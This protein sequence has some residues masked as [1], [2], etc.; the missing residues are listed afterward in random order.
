MTADLAQ[1]LAGLRAFRGKHIRSSNPNPAG[2]DE[3]EQWNLGWQ[4]A[5]RA[6]AIG[7]RANHKARA[8]R[9]GMT[10]DEYRTLEAATVGGC[11]ICQGEIPEVRTPVIDHDHRSNEIRG[12]LCQQCNTG[13]GNFGDSIDRLLAAVD[14]LRKPPAATLL[15]PGPSFNREARLELLTMRTV[16]FECNQCGRRRARWGCGGTC[17]TCTK[18]TL[19]RLRAESR[20]A[21]GHEPDC[22]VWQSHWPA[23]TCGGLEPADGLVAVRTEEHHAVIGLVRW[24]TNKATW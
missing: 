11:M 14:Y 7:K 2:S 3:H 20:R 23:C 10:A 12:L 6:A 1:Y 21:H 5:Y 17:S 13:L 8:A 15:E 9:Y 19:A 18:E 24:A 22:A 16:R 4:A